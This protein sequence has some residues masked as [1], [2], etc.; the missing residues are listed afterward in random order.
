MNITF[1]LFVYTGLG[2][3]RKEVGQ[4][5]ILYKRKSGRR[6]QVEGMS[7]LKIIIV[8]HFIFFFLPHT[9]R[10][11]KSRF[12]LFIK[13]VA[14]NWNSLWSLFVHA[15]MIGNITTVTLFILFTQGERMFLPCFEK[16]KERRTILHLRMYWVI[17]T[18]VG[19]F[20][21][22]GW[23]SGCFPASVMITWTG[24]WP[25]GKRLRGKHLDAE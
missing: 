5:Q 14:G 21:C 22:M 4:M 25:S 19:G 9:K 11:K 13:I 8:N 6:I 18:D 7:N 10:K 2:L 3:A 17:W 12:C 23:E 24:L 15:Q 20:H 1:D 16:P